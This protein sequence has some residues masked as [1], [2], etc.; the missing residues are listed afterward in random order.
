MATFQPRTDDTGIPNSTGVS[1]GT[2]PNKSFAALFEGLTNT[3]K[4]VINVKDEQTQLNI[5]KDA[6]ATFDQTN[7]EFGLAPPDNGPAGLTTELERVQALQSAVEQGK[8]SQVNYYGR[9]ATLSKQLRTKYPGY[10]Q[11][12][13]STIQSVTGTRPANAYR[14]AIFSELASQSD[15]VSTEEKFKRQYIK[16]NEAEINVAIGEDFFTD[17]SKYDFKKVQSE[18]AKL[19]GKSFRIQSEKQELE[20][21]KGRGEYNDVQAAKVA[22][23][24]LSFIVLST[25]NKSMGANQPSARQKMDEFIAKGGGSGQELQTFIND[26]SSAEATL[27]SSLNETV[28]RD[29]VTKGLVT[30][31]A[32]NKMVED[33]LYPITKAKEA[34]V[35]GD[36]KLAS[37]YATINK[38]MEDQLMTTMMQDQTVSA[39]I[40]LKNINEALGDTFFSENR[41][42]TELVAQEAA[43]RI[44]GGDSGAMTQVVTSGNQQ[45]A[46]STLDTT[47]KAIK[48]PKLTG[49]NFSNA[50]KGTFGPDAPSWMDASKNIVAKEDREAL[51]LKFLDP[52]VT[53]AI[54]A[55]GTPED[56][57]M[58]TD[59]ATS[60]LPSVPSLKAAAGDVNTVAGLD[61]LKVEYDAKTNKVQ[62]RLSTGASTADN[63]F[64]GRTLD[65]FNKVLTVLTP[66]MEANGIAKEEIGREVLK[67]LGVREGGGDQKS[68]FNKIWDA[69]P[70]DLTQPISKVLPQAGEKP[71]QSSFDQSLGESIQQVGP[72]MD[73]VVEG[74][75]E[76]LGDLV[77]PV[78]AADS[79]ELDF[80][81]EQP[82]EATPKSA[83]AVTKA[84]SGPYTGPLE[85]FATEK[86][87]LAVATRFVGLNEKRDRNVIASFIKK[88]G[89]QNINPRV[90]AW[91]AAFVNAALG[92]K[93]LEGTGKLNARSFLDYGTPT[94]KPSEGDI[95]VLSRGNSNWKGHVGFFVKDNGD[96]ISMLGGNQGNSVSVEEFPKSRILGYRK[97]PTVQ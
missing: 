43:G 59:W 20:L 5:Q 38:A 94:K 22:G 97:P 92:A 80:V 25:L 76:V 52:S 58:Y 6:Q 84:A 54:V 35:G 29:Y 32:A 95:V 23:Q 61:N 56:L 4:N 15:A 42:Q 89:G 24:E 47:F 90:T 50:I 30:P 77:T 74:A 31:E 14:D 49:E 72:D 27:R 26:I 10:E 55:K 63:K 1:Q 71:K 39:G 18:V 82:A 67:T 21:M 17:P 45:V 34:V 16:E 40:G 79:G 88:A 93:G 2:G 60:V 68:I 73:A 62:F 86:T 69:L 3:A 11:I 46:R 78:E 51:F 19:K 65:A 48:D 64:Y 12:V 36:F 83:V 70:T 8:I 44:I 57:K 91:C 9:L 66:I 75:G 13:D 33:A 53:A 37:K 41:S 28:Q 85:E 96:T 87:P 7:E 81:F